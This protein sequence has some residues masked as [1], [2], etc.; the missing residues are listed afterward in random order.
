MGS[1]GVVMPLILGSSLAS[2]D[3]AL[4][5]G[6]TLLAA[7]SIAFCGYRRRTSAGAL[8]RQVITLI[9]SS[10]AWAVSLLST[11]RSTWESWIAIYT[12]FWIPMV[13]MCAVSLVA[14]L[15]LLVKYYHVVEPRPSVRPWIFVVASDF[16]AINL[17]LSN[18]PDA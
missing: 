9:P 13:V 17:L 7:A 6:L 12:L 2:L 14:S 15:V 1:P 8:V 11:L 18:F 16:V 10:G 5:G 3:L 4:W